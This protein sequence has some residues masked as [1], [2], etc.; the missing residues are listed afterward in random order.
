MTKYDIVY[1]R[2][3]STFLLIKAFIILKLQMVIKSK[4]RNNRQVKIPNTIAIFL[5]IFELIIENKKFLEFSRI[6]P[7]YK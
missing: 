4:V 3:K 1:D 2:G 7:S 5:W 6:E